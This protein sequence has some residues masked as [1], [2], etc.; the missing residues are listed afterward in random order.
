LA[1]K[2]CL[3]CLECAKVPKVEGSEEVLMEHDAMQ[4]HGRNSMSMAC[5]LATD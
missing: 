1:Y 2:K 4:V 3:K 5:D